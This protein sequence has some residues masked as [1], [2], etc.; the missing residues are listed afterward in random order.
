[1]VI[2]GRADNA[3]LIPVE[4]LREISDEEYAVFVMEDGEPKMRL[5]EVGLQD[6]IY[7]EIISG[8]S[9]G[10]VVTTGQVETGQ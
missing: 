5:V 3:V 10:D 2:G 4:A 8:L 7:A 9:Q 1:D 6:L